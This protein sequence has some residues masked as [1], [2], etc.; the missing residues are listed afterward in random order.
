MS[1]LLYLK[2]FLFLLLLNHLIINKLYIFE[3]NNTKKIRFRQPTYNKQ[4]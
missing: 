3:F 2:T 1:Y 4:K